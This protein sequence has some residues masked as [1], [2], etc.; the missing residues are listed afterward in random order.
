MWSKVY[1]RRKISNDVDYVMLMAY[2]EHWATSQTAG[3]IASRDWTEKGIVESLKL[4]PKEKL[5]LG[6]PLFT[7][8]WEETNTASSKKMK[9]TVLSLKNVEKF[10]LDNKLSIIHDESTG[11]NY[12]EYTKDSKQY[13]IW[14]E[15]E[16]SILMRLDLRRKYDLSGVATW[17]LDFSSF[18]YFNYIDKNIE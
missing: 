6:M 10:I 18:D 4:I 1:D 15:D 13:R 16:K 9:S 12:T 5:I 2:D 14:L 17:S 8:I 3:S 11:Q 7:R